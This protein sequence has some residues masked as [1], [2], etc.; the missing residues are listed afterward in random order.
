MFHKENSK[1]AESAMIVAQIFILKREKK[2]CLP[3]AG[4]YHSFRNF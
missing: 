3:K 4:S 2:K 1:D